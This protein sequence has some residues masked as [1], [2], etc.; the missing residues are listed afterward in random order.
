METT[1]FVKRK[2]IALL[3][4]SQ[5]VQGAFAK[6]F[7]P[8]KTNRKYVLMDF[9]PP[10]IEDRNLFIDGFYGRKFYDPIFIVF[11][12][13]KD[14]KISFLVLPPSLRFFSRCCSRQVFFFFF[15]AEL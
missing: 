7:L 2:K 1:V 9:F 10:T 11:V 3:L 15:L 4:S 14:R 13:D 8:T 5:R 6:L 12:A